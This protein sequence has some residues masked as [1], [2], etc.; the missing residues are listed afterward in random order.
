[1]AQLIGLSVK[2]KSEN[3]LTKPYESHQP[4]FGQITSQKNFTMKRVSTRNYHFL[5]SS[6]TTDMQ[7]IDLHT[8]DGSDADSD[9]DPYHSEK[10]K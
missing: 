5:C 8:E 4:A 10:I 7:I 1:M 9:S 2:Q 3:I 6:T